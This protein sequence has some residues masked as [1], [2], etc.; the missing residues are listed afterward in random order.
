MTVIWAEAEPKRTLMVTGDP[1]D[2]KVGDPDVVRLPE[3]TND[4]S[5]PA[6]SWTGAELRTKVRAPVVDARVHPSVP[7]EVMLHGVSQVAA[8]VPVL[9]PAKTTSQE[10]AVEHVMGLPPSFLID[11]VIATGEL[12]EALPAFS[13]APTIVT[14]VLDVALLTRLYIVAVTTPPTP[15]T[16]AIMMKRSR[17]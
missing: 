2:Q 7:P 4:D 13:E 3:R 10:V 11:T 12:D 5:A 17:L 15:S 9:V 6:A 16:A 8:S 1:A 14:L